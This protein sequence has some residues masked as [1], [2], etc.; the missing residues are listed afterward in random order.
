MTD[1][2][3]AHPMRPCIIHAPHFIHHLPILLISCHTVCA[4][5]C[6]THLLQSFSS[7]ESAFPPS[8][9]SSLLAYR[10]VSRRQRQSSTSTHVDHVTLRHVVVRHVT[11]RHATPL[12]LDESTKQ[13]WIQPSKPRNKLNFPSQ[14]ITFPVVDP[15]TIIMTILTFVHFPFTSHPMHLPIDR[16]LMLLLLLLLLVMLLLTSASTSASPPTLHTYSVPCL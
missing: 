1:C 11:P 5:S 2:G 7:L 8:H 9:W 6:V 4:G 3:F 16:S 12:V 13:A 15:I 14:N 10:H